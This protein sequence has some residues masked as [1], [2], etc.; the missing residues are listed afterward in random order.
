MRRVAVAGVSLAR[1]SE[2]WSS[3]LK[4]LFAET[5][6]KAFDDAGT[7]GID[8]LYVSNMCAAPLQGQ[9]H[10]GA[11]M[12]NVLGKRGIH[13]VRVEAGSASGGVAFHEAVKA[14]ASG[15]SDCTLVGGVEKM[16]DGLPGQVYAALSMSEDQ[17][18]TAYTGI[19]RVGLNALIHRRYM[20]RFGASAEE[21]AMFA[22]RSHDNAVGSPHAQYPFRASIDR[23][24]ASPMEADPIHMLECAGV[25]DGAA[26]LVLVPADGSGGGVEVAATTVAT[27]TYYLSDRHDLLTFDAVGHAASK[28]YKL[29][30]V[31]PGEVDVLEV[32]D[33][34]TISG[35]LS[36]EDLGFVEKGKGAVY[37]ADGNTKRDGEFPT[38]TFG[39]L[40]ARGHP[41]GATGLYQIGEVALQLRGEAGPCQVDGARV[42]LAESLGGVGSTCAV[43]ILRGV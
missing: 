30:G 9:L 21:V 37:A 36:L 3:G 17:E 13:A 19:T 18:Y 11:M 1:V 29:A 24:M 42:G 34:T 5:A 31:S 40:K 33:D 25:G 15:F 35:V 38:N 12:A 16:S 10:L 28:A 41:L 2:H 23:I 43:T 8:A 4:D 22:V 32:H 7:D 27:D 26:A 39:G 20:E 6:L 14:V